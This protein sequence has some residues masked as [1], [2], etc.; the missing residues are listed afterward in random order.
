MLHT[1]YAL[2][3]RPE[4]RR[5]VLPPTPAEQELLEEELFQNNCRR[6][7][8]VWY[9][10]ILV[11]YEY[12]EYCALLQLPYETANSPYKCEEEAIVWICENQLERKE[13][14]SSM[15]KYLIG[16]RSITE[17]ALGAHKLSTLRQRT[18]RRPKGVN[19]ISKYDSSQTST[20][21][22]ISRQY[23]VGVTTVW[24]YERYADAIDRIRETVPDFVEAHLA[25][26]IRLSL[27][28]A[29]AISDLSP[30]KL[31]EECRLIQEEV[32]SGQPADWRKRLRPQPVR[33]RQ[34]PLKTGTIKDMPAYDPDAEISSLA[35]TIPSWCSSI[36]RV[37]D[38]VDFTA[39]TV[40]ARAQLFRMLEEL[41]DSVSRMLVKA[42][43]AAG[44]AAGGAAEVVTE[45]AAGVV[46]EGIAEG[47]AEV[48]TDVMAEE[49]VQRGDRHGIQ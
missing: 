30:Q 18:T 31:R 42:E 41:R 33:V 29:I 45:D 46:T 26:K 39:T 22:R 8:R 49:G 35:L 34:A 25:G 11:D 37:C 47:A 21:E 43:D 38:T 17:I 36:R 44:R 2:K 4:F 23:G 9:N 19:S 12:Y 7:I 16:K 3:T 6:V 13:L 32:K 10:T 1:A 5:L 14:P 40:A 15:W 24:K 48:A 20:R 27:E 28:R